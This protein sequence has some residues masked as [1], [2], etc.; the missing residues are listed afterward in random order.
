MKKIYF[1]LSFTLIS[2]MSFS[3]V[4][5][6]ESGTDNGTN[7]TETVSGITATVTTSNNDAQLVNGG[8]FEGSS[9]NVA[10]TENSDSSSSLTITF[11]ASIDIASMYTFIADGTVGPETTMDFTPTGG[12]N[13]VVTEGISQSAGEVV[14]LNWTGIT[15]ITLTV[16]GGGN[17]T[18]GIDDIVLGT[19]LSNTDF[20]I[21]N[22]NLKL[23]PNPSNQFIKISG[24]TNTEKYKIYNIL[25]S[26]VAN[27]NVSNNEKIDIKNYANGFYL[28]KLENGN[29]FKF[30]KE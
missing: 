21:S 28:L 18:F 3:Q 2:L 20:T 17:E 7:V 15:A 11:S 5:N 8:G 22:I 9:G 25:G 26:E 4:F 30:I 27:G 10:F 12:S 23:F 16:N 29:T 14:I 19:T 24:L 6:W 1:T 13:S